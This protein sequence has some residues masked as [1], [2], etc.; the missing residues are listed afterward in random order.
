MK[1]KPKCSCYGG[2]DCEICNPDYYEKMTT[3]DHV[4][5][6]VTDHACPHCGA[7]PMRTYIIAGKEVT[8]HICGSWADSNRE[9]ITD[10]CLIRARAEK[11][12]AEV[13][14][15]WRIIGRQHD[16]LCEHGLAEYGN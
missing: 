4:T 2:F 1:N 13:K 10:L 7:E 5:D 6:H 3:T 16:L 12:E 14:N 8:Q 11:A 15:L 9:E